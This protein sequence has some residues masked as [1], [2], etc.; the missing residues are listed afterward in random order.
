MFIKY[1][2]LGFCFWGIILVTLFCI[3]SKSRI[4]IETME[5]FGKI[6]K[7]IILI[8]MVTTILICTMP[9][10]LSPIWNGEIPQH[11]NQ[12]ELMA[13]AI[14]EGHLYIDYQDVDP[15]LLEMDNPYDRGARD[16][17]NVEYH[18]DHAFYNGHY[19]MYFGVVP[20]FLLFLPYRVITGTSLVTFHATQIFV[21]VFICGVFA[22]FYIL[23]RKFFDQITF[24]MYLFLA[25]AF[26]IMSV[27]YS[28]GT[29]ALYCTAITSA[30]CMEI[31]SLFFFI[32]AV[33][34]EENEKISI[35][36]AFLGSLLGA[37]A[38]GC[39]P[40]VALANLLV[41]PML[42]EYI[43]KRGIHL[44]VLKQL[45]FA[46]TP[47]IIV[48]LLLMLYNYARFNNPF[49]FGQAYQLTITDQSAYGDFAAQFDLVKIVNGVLQNFI[50]YQPISRE[51][52]YIS[53]SGALVN[54]PILIFSMIGLGREEMRE[55][56]T[57]KHL[58][59]FVCGGVILPLLITVI[60]VLWAPS[61]MSER[62]RMDIYWLM[63]IVCFIIIGFY[64]MNLAGLSQKRFS[65]S[66]CVWAL[67]TICTCF[68]LFLVPNDGNYTS[69]VSGVLEKFER[70]L[71][72]GFWG[73]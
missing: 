51:F 53:F 58:G 2:I 52:P 46:A 68:L 25:S 41:I 47:Y 17:L 13:E 15:L 50:S 45:V 57:R 9:M 60:D 61:L 21:A 65:R 22:T 54:F 20:V 23:S 29:P 73:R 35:L 5:S 32:R 55:E 62:Y 16:E 1:F 10:G 34:I 36:Y 44:R 70:V 64:S 18:W 59:H 28:I 72:L 39:R 67:I 27:W 63:G 12:Y 7:R 11:R 37:L 14:L 33:W 66:V 69:F 43:R 6:K 48:G 24:V 30:L 4:H 71:K 56:L 26:S 31:W 49:E 3:R 38:F 8:V 42:V 19:Y 40:P